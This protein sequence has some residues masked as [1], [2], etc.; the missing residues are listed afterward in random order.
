[1]SNEFRINLDDYSEAELKAAIH[2]KRQDDRFWSKPLW[3]QILILLKQNGLTVSIALTILLGG[4]WQKDNLI[5]LVYPPPDVLNRQITA[6][7][8]PL[9]VRLNSRRIDG[10]SGRIQV[11]EQQVNDLS[12]LMKKYR[13]PRPVGLR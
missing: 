8:L 10:N 5:E 7:N 13:Y 9:N 4:Y 2:A 11:L 12:Y 1:M 6:H 3:H